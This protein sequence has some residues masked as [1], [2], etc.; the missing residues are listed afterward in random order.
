METLP[1]EIYDCTLRDGEQ[2]AGLFFS[3]STKHQLA[4]LIAKTGINGLDIMPCVSEQEMALTK[5]LIAEGFDGWLTAA[6]LMNKQFIDQAKDCGIKRIVI[7]YALSDRLMLLRDPQIRKISEFTGKTIDD[8]IPATVIDKIRQSAIETIVEN[9]HYATQVAGLRVD[10]AGEDSSRADFDFLV[11]CI[12]SFS[13]Y[14][15]HFILCDTVGVLTPAKSHIWVKDLIQ[16]TPGVAFG[17]HYHNDMGMA[18]EN[19]LQSVIAGASLITGTFCGIGERAG[20]VAL[21]Q[22]LNGLRV[23]FGIELAGINYDA[24]AP[25]TN[26]IEQMGV[27]PAPPYSLAAQRHETGVH[28]NSLLSDPKSYDAFDHSSIDIIFGKWSGASNFQY[29]FEK[30]LHNPQPREQYEQMRSTIKSLATEQERY[31]T[32]TEVLELWKNGA[33]K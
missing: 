8:D 1:I 10:F 28:V 21:E 5:T 3:S 33:F 16:S 2:Q 23:R 17:L 13:P 15:E 22:V 6:T 26:Y 7:I 24:I 11:Q 31:F 29:L 18:L 32:A 12:R 19:T 25:V 14:I 27:R 20:N 30:Q 9:L 4:H